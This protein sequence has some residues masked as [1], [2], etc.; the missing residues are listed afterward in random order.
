VTFQPSA[1]SNQ[2]ETLPPAAS[3]TWTPL[4]SATASSTPTGTSTPTY[5]VTVDA[6]GDMM[7][8]R[9]V[10]EQ[11]LAKGPQIVFSGV[12]S[13]LD[14]A[15]I[16][17]GN[18]ECAITSRGFPVKKAFPLKA[19]AQAAQALAMA[20]FD[21]V[22]LANN[23][24]MDY[25]YDGLVDMLSYL[26][27]SGI[28]TVGAGSNFIAAHSPLI[29]THNGLRLAFLAYVDV[30]PENSGFDAQVWVATDSR[31]GIAWA[32]P[33]QI[34]QD[35]LAAKSTADVVI[36]MLHSGIEI[37]DVINNIDNNQ[38]LAAHTAIDSGASLVI[39]SHP[40][41]LQQIERYHGGLIAYSLG[42]FVFDQ[43]QGIANATIILRVVMNRL[44]VESYD[45]V[46]VVIENGLPRLST[47]Q[48]IPAIGTLVA[49][50]EP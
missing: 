4:P 23:H 41:V 30:P 17:I 10:G 38:R 24:V 25:G 49:P 22:S 37:S 39:G 28:G 7:L 43:Y 19:P 32:D 18:L 12:R 6:V 46:P 27:Q 35:I 44:G 14:A 15:D 34:R 50:L 5:Q 47:V 11:I 2:A 29:I 1:P 42:N 13:I 26:S 33:G 40:H 36:V 45:W 21:V 20:G 3:P 31:P 48:E 16:R 9:T 8:A